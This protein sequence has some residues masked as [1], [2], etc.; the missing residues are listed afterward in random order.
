MS[1]FE[2]RASEHLEALGKDHDQARVVLAIVA[3]VVNHRGMAN[4]GAEAG[5]GDPGTDRFRDLR[6]ALVSWFRRR[7][8]DPTEAED[9]TQESFLRISQR[10]DQESLVHF[11]AY[12]FRTARSVLADRHRRRTVRRADAHD[13]LDGDR[14]P[15]DEVD[16]LRT[17]L[18]REKLR[19][20]SAVLRALPERTRLVFVLSRLEGMRY[21]DIAKRMNISVSAVQ[22]HMLRAIEALVLDGTDLA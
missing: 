1:I 14:D 17:L 8:P 16:A 18:A 15:S 19:K 3:L 21:A 10:A 4:G 20:V 6:G 5:R 22:K 11:E 13:T 9:L 2:V 7:V 12:L